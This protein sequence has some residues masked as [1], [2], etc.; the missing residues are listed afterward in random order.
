MKTIRLA[1]LCAALVLLVPRPAAC[2]PP[3]FAFLEVPAGARAAALGGA[4]TSLAQGVEGAFWNAA[5]LEQVRGVQ[6][7]GTHAEYVQTLRHDQ[8]ALA[9]RLFGGGLAASVRAM[10]SEPIDERDELGNLIGS[11]GAHDLEFGLAYGRALAPGLS[12]GA[13]TQLVRERIADASA[14]TYSIDLGARWTPARVPGLRLGVSAEHLGPAADFDLSGS[15]GAP[16]ALPAAVQA[17]GSWERAI[18][19]GAKLSTALEAR[20]TRGRNAVGMMGVELATPGGAN[21]AGAAAL[22]AGLRVN[23]DA[24]SFSLGA[25]YSLGGLRLDYAFVPLRLDLGDTHR[26]S[27]TAQL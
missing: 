15:A 3:G 17:G 24:S 14:M 20:C 22:R 10:Y 11:F 27:F 9:G 13:G 4:F 25:G 6:I 5:A 2:G 26:I 7:S 12:F 1:T 8:F 18:A 21:G 16:V 23:D 19:R